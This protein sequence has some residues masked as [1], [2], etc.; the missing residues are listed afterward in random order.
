VGE[1]PDR[2]LG[3][4]GLAD[5]DRAR[6]AEALDQLVVTAGRRGVG[7]GAA[8]ARRV[9]RDVDA[10]LDRHGDARERQREPV[11]APVDRA[12]LGQH[13]L[14]VV[15]LEGAE[16]PVALRDA[17]QVRARHRHGARAPVVH[18]RHDLGRAQRGAVG[19]VH[20]SSLASTRARPGTDMPS[21]RS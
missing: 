6:R 12:R 3:H 2:E 14:G 18:A 11:G 8:V 5:H 17:R 1:A 13:P 9:T 20:P 19:G 4:A 16:V 15:L 10:V 7:G 21:A